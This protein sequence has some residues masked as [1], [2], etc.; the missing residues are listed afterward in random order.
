[1][2]TVD[3]LLDRGLDRDLPDPMLQYNSLVVHVDLDVLDGPLELGERLLHALVTEMVRIVV[4]QPDVA[5]DVRG[6]TGGVGCTSFG[7]LLS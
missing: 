3:R 7:G 1:M 6:T 5:R 2:I 4:A